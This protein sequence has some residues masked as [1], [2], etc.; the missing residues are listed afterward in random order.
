MDINVQHSD[1][2]CGVCRRF[3]AY[4]SELKAQL[5]RAGFGTVLEIG[6]FSCPKSTTRAVRC[7]HENRPGI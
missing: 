3:R 4:G 7:R 2:G 1:A 5:S 6:I